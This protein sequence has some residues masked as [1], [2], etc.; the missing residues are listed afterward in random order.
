MPELFR[1]D[2]W[3]VR[4]AYA[5]AARWQSEAAPDVRLNVNLPPRELENAD[6]VER[7]TSLLDNSRLDATRVNIEI[8]ETGYIA[9]PEGAIDV[10]PTN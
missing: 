4:T 6:V 10:L 9:E 3:V 5:D 7:F 1:L 8:T 2:S